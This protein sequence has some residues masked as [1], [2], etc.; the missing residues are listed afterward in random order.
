MGGQEGGGGSQERESVILTEYA[1]QLQYI[2]KLTY[3]GQFYIGKPK[4]Q[5]TI[6][7]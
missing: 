6:I 7:S 5:P 1:V 3:I 4:Y 2:F